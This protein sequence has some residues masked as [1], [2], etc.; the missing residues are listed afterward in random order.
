MI[1]HNN[2]YRFQLLLNKQSITA[3][4]PKTNE[5]SSS[6]NVIYITLGMK[7]VNPSII[8]R[9]HI[10]S[11][12]SMGNRSFD[13]FFTANAMMREMMLAE[14]PVMVEITESL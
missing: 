8:I 10:R 7:K 13:Y 6:R 2:L 1:I 9:M 5:N 12:R 14:M 4:E 3:I 11:N